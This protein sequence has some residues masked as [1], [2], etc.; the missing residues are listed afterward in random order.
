MVGNKLKK[1]KLQIRDLRNETGHDGLLCS[2]ELAC[3]TEMPILTT[4]RNSSV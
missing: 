4:E 3:I 1:S 2:Y